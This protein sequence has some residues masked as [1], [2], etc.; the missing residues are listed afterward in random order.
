MSQLTEITDEID[1]KGFLR[2]FARQY[3]LILNYISRIFFISLFLLKQ[4][5]ITK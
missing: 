5:N 2:I 4:E 3:I 1:L